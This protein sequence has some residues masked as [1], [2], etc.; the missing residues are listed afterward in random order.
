MPVSGAARF[1]RR[2][3]LQDRVDRQDVGCCAWS[4]CFSGDV[5]QPTSST[6]AQAVSGA[7]NLDST[8]LTPSL[9]GWLRIWAADPCRSDCAAFPHL[10]ASGDGGP[11]CAWRDRPTP[12]CRHRASCCPS[13]SRCARC[14]VACPCAPCAAPRASAAARRRFRARLRCDRSPRSEHGTARLDLDQRPARL[15]AF[16][17]H[18]DLQRHRLVPRLVLNHRD[19]D[20]RGRDDP[21][22][23]DVERV[24]RRGASSPSL[25]STGVGLRSSLNSGCICDFGECACRRQLQRL[26]VD[27]A[28]AGSG[29][30]LDGSSAAQR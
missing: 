10:R 18:S 21:G 9:L 23:R 28:A 3:R 30:S 12:A 15:I 27:R 20:R 7:M 26:V 16:Q 22:Q 19:L 14:S 5:A 29:G 13:A 24:L 11:R 25:A 17:R 8:W 4:S 6:S 2:S 1:D